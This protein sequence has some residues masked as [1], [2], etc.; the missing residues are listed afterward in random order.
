MPLVGKDPH[1]DV[2]LGVLDPSSPLWRLPWILVAVVPSHAHAQECSV[3]HRLC[4]GGD[5]VVLLVRQVHVFRAETRHHGLDKVKALL[6]RPVLY[7]HQRLARRVHAGPVQGMHRHN[8]HVRRQ[9][10][11]ERAD[12]RALARRL[13]A[14]NRV[15]LR[16]RAV[17]RHDLLDVLRLH[18]V[19]DVVRRSRHVEPIPVDLHLGQQRR[20]AFLQL[21]VPLLSVTSTHA[22]AGLQEPPGVEK[23]HVPEPD[24]PDLLRLLQLL[25]LCLR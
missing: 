20:H 19:D 4:V 10:F 8:L 16:R 2:D 17:Q 24:D 18:R 1:R 14:D 25:D 9:V 11:L 5:L 12:L 21:L 22:P 7:E 6:G 3:R 23:A 15:H 13:P